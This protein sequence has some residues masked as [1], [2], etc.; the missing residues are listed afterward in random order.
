MDRDTF[1]KSF[2]PYIVIDKDGDIQ[3]DRLSF[4]R[5]SGKL[6]NRRIVIRR[7]V[8][9]DKP[10]AV[11]LY[12]MNEIETMLQSVDLR[13]IKCYGDWEGSAVTMNTRRLVL[14]ASKPG[15]PNREHSVSS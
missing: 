8:R 7:G 10:Y 4:D 5:Q 9:S 13:L 11:R 1:L 3:I 15:E 6:V 2:L 14:F 12:N